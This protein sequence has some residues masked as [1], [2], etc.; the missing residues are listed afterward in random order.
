MLAPIASGVRPSL[1]EQETKDIK[2]E[3]EER[4]EEEKEEEEEVG[5]EE[6]KEEE[7]ERFDSVDPEDTTVKIHKGPVKPSQEEV[8]RHVVTHLPYRSWCPI[9]V[10]ARGKEDAHCKI[11][12]RER[13]MPVIVMDYKTFG[14]Q[15]EESKEDK[16]KAIVMRDQISGMIAGHL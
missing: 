7:E 5:K 16:I 1:H 13:G 8:D 4:E 3:E 6:T 14:N 12:V 9:C 10:A 15:M 11:K 2:E